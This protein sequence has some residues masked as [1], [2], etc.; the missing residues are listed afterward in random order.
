MVR[1]FRFL[2]SRR[3]AL[4]AIAVA[5]LVAGTVWLGNW[6]FDRLEERRQSN[7]IISANEGAAPAA[8]EDVLAP[9]RPVSKDDEWRRVRATGTYDVDDTIVWRYRTDDEGVSGIDVVVPLVT[10]DGTRL[11]VD[12]G[13]MPTQ[14]QTD[15]PRIPA[16]PGGEVTLTG[17]VRADGAGDSTS[18]DRVDGRWGTRAVSSE[19]ISRALGVDTY[20]GFVMVESEDPAPA[21]PLTRA[22][23]PELS[24]GPHFFYGLQWWFFGVLAV[25][26]F[27]YLLYDERRSQL[28]KHAAE[29]GEQV[30]D[31]RA[32]RKARRAAKNAHKQQVRAAYQAAYARD[33]ERAQSARVAPPS[34]GTMAP[35]TNEAAGESTNAATRPN[36]SGKP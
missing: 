6:Q 36:S 15:Y 25:F 23:L 28:R 22:E 24:E 14:D 7:G 17:W 31:P 3:W 32:E 4:F 18:V 8:V 29:T 2:L 33:R 27:F 19:Q 26:G 35:D 12:R 16:P 5:V 20:G 9:G 34:T 30:T 11:V 21:T 10:A 1:S 13:W